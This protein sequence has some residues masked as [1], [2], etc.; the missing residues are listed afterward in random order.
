MEEIQETKMELNRMLLAEEDMWQIKG[1]NNV[2]QEDEEIMGRTFV[3][4][5][6]QLFTSSQVEV[7]IELIE[8]IQVK[9]TDRMNTLLLQEFRAHDMEKAL[10][11]MHPL[12]TPGPDVLDFLNN[13][14]APPKFHETHIVLIPKMK[15]PEYVTDYRPISLCNMTYK[16]ASKAVANRLKLVL[17]DIICENQ[18]AFVSERLIT[19]NVLV[20]HELVNHI[21]RRKKGK[22]GEKRKKRRDDPEIRYE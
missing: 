1:S 12:K 2:W 18:S 13:G 4:Y 22:N 7:S 5:F 11:Q 20:A 16:L 21:N 3:E 8:A 14:V 6:T 15:N 9:A 10:K 19:N 17:Q